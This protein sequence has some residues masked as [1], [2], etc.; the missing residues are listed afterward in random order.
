MPSY[1]DLSSDGEN[2]VYMMSDD[3]YSEMPKLTKAAVTKKKGTD[4]GLSRSNKNTKKKQVSLSDD[5]DDSP[6]VADDQPEI[7]PKKK[8]IKKRC[9]YQTTEENINCKYN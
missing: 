3:E 8:V 5:D 4:V 1:C 2:Y 7:K 6:Y 9:V